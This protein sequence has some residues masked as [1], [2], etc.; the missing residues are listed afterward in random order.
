MRRS[1]GVPKTLLLLLG[2][3]CIIAGGLVDW[4]GQRHIL[5]DV[6][7]KTAMVAVV[8]GSYI[9]VSGYVRVRK[10]RARRSRAIA[11]SNSEI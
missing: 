8:L 3:L 5:W 11:Q 10:R 4:Y 1:R 6:F 7:G 9:C 2:V